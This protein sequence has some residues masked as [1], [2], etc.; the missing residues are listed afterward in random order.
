M[1]LKT[2]LVVTALVA[3]LAGCATNPAST[4]GTSTTVSR[5]MSDTTPATP[6]DS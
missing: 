5:P 3:V 1:K 4:S 2:T 6:A